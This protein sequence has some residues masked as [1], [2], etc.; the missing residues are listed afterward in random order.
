MIN[1]NYN[2]T[3][4]LIIY[5]SY[6][7]VSMSTNVQQPLCDFAPYKCKKIICKGLKNSNFVKSIVVNF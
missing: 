6:T 1:L 4:D 3:V 7:L 5:C 2:I